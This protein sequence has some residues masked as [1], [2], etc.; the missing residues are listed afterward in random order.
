MESDG[1]VYYADKDDINKASKVLGITE[2]SAL[3]DEDIDIQSFGAMTD[4]SWNW[5]LT[6]KIYLSTNGLL[7]QTIPTSGVLREIG[8]PISTTSMLINMQ[9][10]IILV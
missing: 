1:K 4:P 8:I 7:T 2:H 6:K 10:A 3:T 9:D 5:D